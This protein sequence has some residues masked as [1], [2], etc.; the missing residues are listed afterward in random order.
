[1]HTEFVHP[2]PLHLRRQ[3]EAGRG[4]TRGEVDALGEE[5]AQ[6]LNEEKRAG[7]YIVDFSS[8][9]GNKALPSGIYIYKITV[10]NFSDSKKMVIL[11]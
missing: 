5:I 3:L 1:M 10:G 8:I 2:S 7:T 11:K 6:L 9:H 4:D